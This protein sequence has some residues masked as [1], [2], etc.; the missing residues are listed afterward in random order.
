MTLAY[1]L[2]IEIKIIK[3]KLNYFLELFILSIQFIQNLE[4]IFY[5]Q[6]E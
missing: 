2:I 1:S 3:L 5:S 4:C 6:I